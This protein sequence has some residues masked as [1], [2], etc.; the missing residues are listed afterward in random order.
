VKRLNGY[1][2]ERCGHPHL[3]P[4]DE[5]CTHPHDGKRRVLT[6]HHLNGDKGECHLWNLAALCQACHLV[7]QGRVCFDQAW[8]WPHSPWMQRHVDRHARFLAR[9]P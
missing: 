6:V 3:D 5:R 4:C 1:R 9:R 8:A 7:I 2:C